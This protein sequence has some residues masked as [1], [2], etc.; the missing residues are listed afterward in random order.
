MKNHWATQS[1]FLNPLRYAKVDY[2]CAWAG[3]EINVDEVRKNKTAWTG[4]VVRDADAGEK[5]E[6]DRAKSNG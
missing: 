3:L 5:A 4:I 6:M 2:F 1:R